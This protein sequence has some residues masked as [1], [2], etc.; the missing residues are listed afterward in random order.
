MNQVLTKKTAFIC[1]VKENSKEEISGLKNIKEIVPQVLSTDYTSKLYSGVDSDDEDAS[2]KKRK[3]KKR[4]NKRGDTKDGEEEDEGV[5]LETDSKKEEK[6]EDEGATFTVS[7]IKSEKDLLE[8]VQKQKNAWI[9][10][11]YR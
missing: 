10:G 9:L 6:K 4:C 2:G 5:K 7:K 3:K 8:V 11:T 1:I